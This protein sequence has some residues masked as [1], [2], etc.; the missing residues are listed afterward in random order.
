M[1][2]RKLF[3]F[4]GLQAHTALMAEEEAAALSTWAVASLCGS[5]RL[6]NVISCFST[7]ALHDYLTVMLLHTHT[8]KHIQS[9]LMVSIR[10]L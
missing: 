7:Y 3:I 10:G 8:K 2:F 6:E 1:T 4:F 5:L 9:S